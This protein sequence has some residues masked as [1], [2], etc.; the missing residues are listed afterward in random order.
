MSD[1]V[2]RLNAALKGRYK[3]VRGLGEPGRLRWMLG[4]AAVLA[5]LVARP[6]LAADISG[7]W[8]ISY[9]MG[10]GRQ[11]IITVELVQEGSRLSGSGTMRAE[12][13]GDAVRVEVRSGTAGNNDVR[14]LLVGEGGSAARPQ[15][16]VGDW[17]RDEMSGLTE[18]AF[19]SRMFTGARSRSPN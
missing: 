14:F 11:T 1:P 12:R 5:F 4:V 2:A 6:L 13:V 17:Y 10:Q 9:Q 18:G 16:F 15:E 7:T 19:G 3:I 8:E